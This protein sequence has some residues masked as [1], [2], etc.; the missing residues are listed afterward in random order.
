MLG[1]LGDPGVIVLGFYEDS[2]I[3]ILSFSSFHMGTQKHNAVSEAQS[4]RLPLFMR[5]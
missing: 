5:P 4:R 2:V 1:L 3:R